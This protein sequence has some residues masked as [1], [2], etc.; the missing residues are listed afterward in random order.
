MRVIWDAEKEVTKAFLRVQS[1]R[2]FLVEDK[3]EHRRSEVGVSFGLSGTSANFSAKESMCVKPQFYRT[4]GKHHVPSSLDWQETLWLNWKNFKT[5]QVGSDQNVPLPSLGV[6]P[7][8]FQDVGVAA[9]LNQ[10]M[11]SAVSPLHPAYVLRFRQ[12]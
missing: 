5:N 8:L 4:L 11:T 9:A 10:L 2:V 1:R 7:Q 12:K 3:N 6:Q